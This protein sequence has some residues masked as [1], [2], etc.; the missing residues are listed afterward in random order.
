MACDAGRQAGAPGGVAT[1]SSQGNREK[2]KMTRSG[3]VI[4]SDPGPRHHPSQRTMVAAVSPSATVGASARQAKACLSA[5]LPI[6]GRS[7]ILS[8]PSSGTITMAI[9]NGR[10]VCG[11][12]GGIKQT[13]GAIIAQ[14]VEALAR[15]GRSLLQDGSNG[16]TQ[17]VRPWR[18]G[19]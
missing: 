14:L 17:P 2:E 5:S 3:Y 16:R 13:I 18:P 1:V 12:H 7:P 4:K 9:T 10:I 8:S 15:K 6:W 19:S 11:R